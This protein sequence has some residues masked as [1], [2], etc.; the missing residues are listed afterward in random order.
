MVVAEVSDPPA[1]LR[2]LALPTAS[3]APVAASAG[4]VDTLVDSAPL[5]VVVDSVDPG[6]ATEVAVVD[7][8][9]AVSLIISLSNLQLNLCF[10][11]PCDSSTASA[12][13]SE[14]RVV[15]IK[16]VSGYSRFLDCKINV[17]WQNQ[18]IKKDRAFLSTLT[19]SK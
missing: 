8:E 14:S 17:L 12:M 5:A 11:A 4:P 3:G 18:P 1:R 6:A 15:C 16:A 2:T 7:L 9:E 10:P 13:T 19:L